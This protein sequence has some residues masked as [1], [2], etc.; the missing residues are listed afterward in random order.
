M[1][2]AAPSSVGCHLQTRAY[3]PDLLRQPEA[4]NKSTESR[5][6]A[7]EEASAASRDAHGRKGLSLDLYG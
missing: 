1:S 3:R 6:D 7:P 5:A 4:E 2:A